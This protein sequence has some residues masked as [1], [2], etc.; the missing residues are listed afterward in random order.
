[1]RTTD[2]SYTILKYRHDAAAGETLNVG[3]VLFAPET[4]EVGVHF[5]QRYGR[6]SEAFAGFD[7]D[8][9]RSALGR[10][11]KA[12]ETMS[13]PMSGGL[14][15]LEERERFANVG[16]LV[17]AAWPDQGLGYFTGPVLF[18]VAEDLDREL[19]DLYDRFVL[20]QQDRREAQSRFNDEA[21]WNALRKV[22]TPRGNTQ[23]VRRK[24]LAPRKSSFSTPTRMRSGTSSSRCRSTTPMQAT[25]SRG[26]C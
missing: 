5:S 2:Y 14:F 6:L 26:H 9:Y 18:G 13:R 16:A 19:D 22:V 24:A 12:L 20:S 21:V 15:Q 8:L 23:V 4:G 7:G 17:R 1:M 25:L 10:L 3:V 11:Q